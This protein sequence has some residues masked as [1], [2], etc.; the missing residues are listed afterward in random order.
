MKNQLSNK[1]T[2]D[3]ISIR[4]PVS[5]NYVDT[6]FNDPLIKKQYTC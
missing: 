1:N 5:K 4:E 2:K 6:F 3:P